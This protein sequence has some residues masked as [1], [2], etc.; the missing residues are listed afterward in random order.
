MLHS[1]N[2]V[3]EPGPSSLPLFGFGLG[4][5]LGFEPRL[6]QAELHPWPHMF[7]SDMPF[8]GIII[9]G[10]LILSLDKDTYEETGLQGR[11]AQHSGKK[12]VKFS[13]YELSSASNCTSPRLSPHPSPLPRS[14]SPLAGNPSLP[15]STVLC[16]PKSCSALVALRSR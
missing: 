2:S 13:E 1:D 4:W 5:V 7:V 15:V 11:P 6:S 3:R 8:L 14:P 12:T 9:V 10:K 16:K